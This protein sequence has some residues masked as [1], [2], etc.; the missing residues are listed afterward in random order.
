MGQ[1]EVVLLPRSILIGCYHLHLDELVLIEYVAAA[2]H[3]PS[4]SLVTSK[5]LTEF[6]D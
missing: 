1:N 2:L 3:A 6:T 4:A 5:S